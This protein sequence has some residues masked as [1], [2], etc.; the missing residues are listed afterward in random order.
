MIIIGNQFCRVVHITP[1][2]NTISFTISTFKENKPRNPISESQ[3][4][5]DLS[6]R[7]Q[8]YGIVTTGRSVNQSI[9]LEH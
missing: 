6:I 7:P 2:T 9:N 8:K 4:I 1:E 3:L 5:L